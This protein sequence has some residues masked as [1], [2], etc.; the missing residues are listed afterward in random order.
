MNVGKTAAL[1][2]VGAMAGAVNGLF[3]TG[4]GTVMVLLIPLLYPRLE[5]ERLFA[6][7]C[8]AVLPLSVVSALTYSSF[9]PPDLGSALTVGVGA[10]AGGAVGA[11]LL[12]RLKPS[13]LKLIFSA[14]MAVSGAIMVFS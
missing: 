4:G 5:G 8:A 1:T 6:N 9:A 2:A 13:V 14:M 11:I 3:G 7:V 10:L 12:G